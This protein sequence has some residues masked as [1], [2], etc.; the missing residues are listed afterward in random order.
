MPPIRDALA[1]LKLATTTPDPQP[2]DE[3]D[4]ELVAEAFTQEAIK[5]ENNGQ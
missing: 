2:I 1:Q 5:L 4:A 3:G